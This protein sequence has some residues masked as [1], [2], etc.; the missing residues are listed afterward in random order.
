MTQKTEIEIRLDKINVE[1]QLIINTLKSKFE[2]GN[3]SAGDIS[4]NLPDAYIEVLNWISSS[5]NQDLKSANGL[6]VGGTV[7]DQLVMAFAPMYLMNQNY[8]QWLRDSLNPNT[9]TG[10]GRRMICQ[11]MDVN[12]EEA[13]PTQVEL[14]VKGEPN[15]IIAPM[16]LLINTPDTSNPNIKIQLYNQDIIVLNDVGISMGNFVCQEWG[17]VIITSDN[18]YTIISQVAGVN[19]VEYS[20]AQGSNISIG[21]DEDTDE[22][23]K[24]R[25]FFSINQKAKNGYSA[26]ENELIANLPN[27]TSVVT[28]INNADVAKVLPDNIGVTQ[29]PSNTVVCSLSC[30]DNDVNRKAIAQTMHYNRCLQYGYPLNIPDINQKIASYTAPNNIIYTYQWVQTTPIKVYFTVTINESH[31]NYAISDDVIKKAIKDQFTQ[32]GYDHDKVVQGIPFYVQWFDQALSTLGL[33]SYNITM[34]FIDKVNKT[35]LCSHI[36]D[37]PTVEDA[38]IVINWSS[39]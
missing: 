34:S 35:M 9:A 1:N 27:A 11:I 4:G 22:D 30:Q 24:Q 38:T 5:F 16:S 32:G 8:P 17:N 13:Q 3:N 6:A 14:L 39:L 2:N 19:S 18:L 23:L 25:C 10:A 12:I 7:M 33:P 31:S 37:L 15:T 29:V 26:L 28:M 36:W 21:Q 20:T